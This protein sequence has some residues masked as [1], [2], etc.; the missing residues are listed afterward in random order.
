MVKGRCSGSFP[1]ANGFEDRRTYSLKE[2][3]AKY[4][5]T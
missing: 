1:N 5:Q 3:G 4:T 2:K